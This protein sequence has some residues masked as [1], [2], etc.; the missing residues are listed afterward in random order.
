MPP[1]DEIAKI[2][3]GNEPL[4]AIVTVGKLDNFTI[5]HL[6]SPGRF[7]RYPDCIILAPACSWVHRLI[8]ARVRRLDG[9]QNV[10]A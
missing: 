6:E 4:R 3:S 2:S 1:H 8:F 9:A 7:G 10:L 5:G